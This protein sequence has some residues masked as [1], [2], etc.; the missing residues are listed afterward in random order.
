MPSYVCT[1]LDTDPFSGSQ[2]CLNWAELPSTP[3]ILPDLTIAQ[4]N[5]LAAAMITVLAI[6]WCFKT[7][8]Q[9]LK[10]A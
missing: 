1:Q 6:A 2:Q 5:T 8:A 7:L 3:P 4:A 9:Y 10:D